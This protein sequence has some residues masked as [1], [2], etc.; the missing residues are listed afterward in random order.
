MCGREGEGWKATFPPTELT[1]L[2]V[3]RASCA[4]PLPLS[5][6]EDGR[7]EQ[8]A[9]WAGMTGVQVRTIAPE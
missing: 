5:V 2:M 1:V 6:M 3:A 7:R 4:V 9:Y 8:L